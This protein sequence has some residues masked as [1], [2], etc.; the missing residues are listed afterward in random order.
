MSPA[1]RRLHALW[2]RPG[3]EMADGWWDKLGLAG[4]RAAYAGQALTRPALDHLIASRLGHAGGAPE[5]SPLA[6]ALLEDDMRREALCAALGLW[7]L[8]CPDYLL[9]KPYREALSAVLD[10]R[11]QTQLQALLPRG[12]AAA[13]LAP[14]ELPDA[15]RALGAAWLADA[16]EPSLRLCRLLWAPSAQ[17]APAAPLEPALQ[18][19]SRWL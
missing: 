5:P 11:A 6:E 13:E 9:L 2:R 18:K 4:W 7:A 19:L 16:A 14:A 3:R 12:A 8:R 17:A 10:A 1:L 15:A